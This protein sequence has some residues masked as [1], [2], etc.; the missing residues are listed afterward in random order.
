LL[1]SDA[2]LTT[3][4]QIDAAITVGMRVFHMDDLHND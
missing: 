1:I 4:R 2:R 3:L